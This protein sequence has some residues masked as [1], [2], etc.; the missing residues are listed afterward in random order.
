MIRFAAAWILAA[1]VHVAGLAVVVCWRS[2]AEPDSP[3]TLPELQLTSVELSFSEQREIEGEV[4]ASAAPSVPAPP[5][6]SSLV[7]PEARLADALPVEPL[8]PDVPSS[9]EAP[10]ARLDDR[11]PVPE[12]PEV[13]AM[14]SEPSENVESAKETRR[15]TAQVDV[16][17]QPQVAFRPV[18]PRGCRLRREEGVVTV[19]IAV[20]AEGRVESVQVVQSSGFRELDEAA[21]AAARRAAFAPAVRE[22][23]AVSG[24]VQ[25]PIVFRLLK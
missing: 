10:K 17:P 24:T 22:G 1:L 13:P 9:P 15:E 19:S 21:V 5:V 20:T 7:P 12:L 25:V 2:S 18:Y 4:G 16:P 23:R 14:A 11:L 8:A 3:T 6:P